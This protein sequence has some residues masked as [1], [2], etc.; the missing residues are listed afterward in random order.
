MGI[1][2]TNS[3]LYT[4]LPGCDVIKINLIIK[5]NGGWLTSLLFN[6]SETKHATKISTTD[7]VVISIALSNK[8]IKKYIDTVYI[9]LNNC[10]CLS[11]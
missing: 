9:P 11:P 7:F 4:F 6:I 1:L 3:K 5:Q 8:P 10:Y 2:T